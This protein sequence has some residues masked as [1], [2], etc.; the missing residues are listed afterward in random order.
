[1][2]DLAKYCFEEKKDW[3]ECMLNPLG[4][5]ITSV[6]Y[7]YDPN[8]SI[9]YSLRKSSHPNSVTLDVYVPFYGFIRS[10][11]F[12]Y[13][14]GEQPWQGSQGGKVVQYTTLRQ[15]IDETIHYMDKKIISDLTSDKP[16]IWV[17]CTDYDREVKFFSK[18]G[19]YCNAKSQIIAD[20]S[21]QNLLNRLLKESPLEVDD[22]YIYILSEVK[23]TKTPYRLFMLLIQDNEKKDSKAEL[24]TYFNWKDIK[25]RKFKPQEDDDG[26]L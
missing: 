7:G 9:T 24:F 17:K 11:R 16:W 23:S 12:T 4:L 14:G 10:F 20:Q 21:T 5:N 1:M 13:V 18:E 19:E 26:P 2:E 15:G 25:D 22:R 3:I 8:T 6:K